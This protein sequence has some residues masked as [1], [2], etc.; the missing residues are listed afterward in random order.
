M[1]RCWQDRIPYDPARHRALQ[2][3]ITV[4][5]PTASGPVIDQAATER[6]TLSVTASNRPTPDA[7]R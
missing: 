2:R 3:H 1:W 5:I 7:C 6:M 4:T